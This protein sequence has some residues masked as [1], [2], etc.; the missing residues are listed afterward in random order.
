MAGCFGKLARMTSDVMEAP[1]SPVTFL[2]TCLTNFVTARDSTCFGVDG[3]AGR[4]WPN[5]E[6]KHCLNIT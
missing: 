6:A 2:V 1:H 5:M 3:A 4:H